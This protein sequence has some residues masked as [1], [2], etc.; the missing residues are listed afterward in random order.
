M[1]AI[2]LL[3]PF[4]APSPRNPRAVKHIMIFLQQQLDP[5]QA[6]LAMTDVARNFTALC[7]TQVV[8]SVDDAVWV[9]D[10]FGMQAFEDNVQALHVK[11]CSSE[12]TGRRFEGIDEFNRLEDDVPD[13]DNL[14]GDGEWVNH[15]FRFSEDDVN[16]RFVRVRSGKHRR[17][18]A[19]KSGSGCYSMAASVRHCHRPAR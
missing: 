13:V 18:G 16:N 9:I 5:L 3:L 4:G 11:D 10:D 6:A 14:P 17:V 12:F 2:D 7:G 1:N 19:F 8:L 15:R